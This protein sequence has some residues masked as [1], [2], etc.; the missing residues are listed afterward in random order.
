M[1][2]TGRQ[3]IGVPVREEMEVAVHLTLGC[4]FHCL[5]VY[6]HVYP[7]LASRQY[8][9]VCPLCTCVG[10]IDIPIHCYKTPQCVAG[11]PLIRA[12]IFSQIPFCM[13][14]PLYTL[15]S[16][17]LLVRLVSPFFRNR[18]LLQTALQNCVSIWLQLCTTSS[19]WV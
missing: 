18:R 15:Y 2:T 6:T 3:C 9:Y 13:P 4:N 1:F 14:L 19:W 16:I 11:V 10:L 8:V 5:H 17:Q 12:P 7:T